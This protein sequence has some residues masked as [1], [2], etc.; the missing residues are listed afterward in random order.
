MKSIIRKILNK[1]SYFKL[2][3]EAHLT[4]GANSVVNYR[5]FDLQNNKNCRFVIGEKSLV[6][7]SFVFEKEGATIEI[8]RNTFI[9]GSVLSCA[10]KIKIGENVFIAWNVTIFDHNSHSL[11]Y[12]VRRNDLPHLFIGKKTWEDVG[13]SPTIIEEDVW[14]GVNA[15]IL[16]GITIGKGSIIAAGAVVTKNVPPNTLV[17]GNPA[18]V[19]KDLKYD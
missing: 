17:A 6:S 19:V 1:Y 3:K 9:G 4:I 15:I 5:S 10:E 11:N 18:Q 12:N 16:K 8:G 14:V 13:I 2:R 7:A